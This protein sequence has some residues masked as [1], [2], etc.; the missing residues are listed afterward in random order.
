MLKVLV[1][2]LPELNYEMLMLLIGFLNLFSESLNSPP[3]GLLKA[4]GI[5][6]LHP[7]N[8]CEMLHY[9]LEA[10]GDVVRLL[11]LEKDALFKVTPPPPSS[12]FLLFF[13]ENSIPRSLAR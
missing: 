9:E 3:E 10:V 4:F 1:T 12:L 13:F 6:I 5:A 8:S 7:K 11:L 2:V